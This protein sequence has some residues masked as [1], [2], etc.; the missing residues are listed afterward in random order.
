MAQGTDFSV[1]NLVQRKLDETRKLTQE[2]LTIRALHALNHA[3]K[4]R[5]SHDF[6]EENIG[7]VDYKIHRTAIALT[8]S[9]DFK[10]RFGP[11]S[12]A[13]GDNKAMHDFLSAMMTAE[14][15]ISS[16]N[17]GDILA[18]AQTLLAAGKVNE[19]RDSLNDLLTLMPDDADVR[20]NAGELYLTHSLFE[21]AELVF[22]EAQALRPR[23]IHIIN[24]LGIAF[25][26]MGRYDD[27]SA[28]Y[29]KAIKI[30]P[31]DANLYYNLAA[32]LYL[33]HDY[34][35]AHRTI[36]QALHI[37]PDFQEGKELEGRIAAAMKQH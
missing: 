25:R 6:R 20:L 26:K 8:E 36:R 22:R 28:E 3:L 11:V 35:G 4:L 1:V 5:I 30:A 7:Q 34:N 15:E 32:A 37:Q 2:G 19:A 23:S 27:A 10:G 33:K 29:L 13:Q 17:A 12:F 16:S 18:R 31:D 14:M 24:R 9:E 21:D